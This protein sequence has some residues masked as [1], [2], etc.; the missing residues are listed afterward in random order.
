MSKFY[1][2]LIIANMMLL[3]F[4]D[5]ILLQICSN[6]TSHELVQLPLSC[7]A[8]SRVAFDIYQARIRLSR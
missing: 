8:L 7:Q 6:L 4:A 1:D 2:N 5:E 3:D